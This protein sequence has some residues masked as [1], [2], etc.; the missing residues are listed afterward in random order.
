MGYQLNNNKATDLY[1]MYLERPNKKSTE[2]ERE[3]EIKPLSLQT[4][5]KKLKLDG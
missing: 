3:Q 5:W 4:E 1:G 2:Q